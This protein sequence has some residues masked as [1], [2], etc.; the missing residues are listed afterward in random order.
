[1]ATMIST[2]T[3]LDLP[4]VHPHYPT[5]ARPTWELALLFPAQGFWTQ[6]EYFRLDNVFDGG[7]R[8]ELA[9]GILEVLPMPTELHQSITGYLYELVKAWAR[10]HAPGKVSFSGLRVRVSNSTDPKFREPDVAYMKAANAHRRHNEYWESADLLMEVVSEDPKD[11]VRDYETKS[12]D[13]AQAGVPEY[14]IV[15]PFQKLIRVLVLDGTTYRLHGDFGP[16]MKATSV[17]WPGFEVDVTTA[18][19]GGED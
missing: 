12:N 3:P 1:M 15:D 7:F 14:W 17:L 10:K 19:A 13:Y 5:G 4:A 11:Q 16:G 9:N 8:A 6:E 18:L 2:T